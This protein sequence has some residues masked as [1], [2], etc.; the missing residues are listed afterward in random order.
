[1]SMLRKI[2]SVIGSVAIAA[3]I[4]PAGSSQMWWPSGGEE[5]RYALFVDGDKVGRSDISFS[6]AD[7]GRLSVVQS[8]NIKTEFAGMTAKFR[9]TFRENWQGQ[10]FETMSTFGMIATSAGKVRMKVL[11]ELDKDGNQVVKSKLG[12]RK[13]ADIR[14]PATFWHLNQLTYSDIFDPYAGGFASLDIENLGTQV[15]EIDG[16]TVP[17]MAFNLN[18]KYIDHK[19]FVKTPLGP[20]PE[21]IPLERTYK[22]WFEPNGLMCAL[23]FET[24]VGLF[25]L[26]R[27][28]THLN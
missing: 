5:V 8:Q 2:S 15:L 14:V 17:C 18:I 10:D 26:A 12:E 19:Q 9:A 25:L 22:A 21:D 7:D 24:P 28:E 3:S 20:D 4:T 16:G 6:Y 1:M 13:S 27:Q 11:A 23:S